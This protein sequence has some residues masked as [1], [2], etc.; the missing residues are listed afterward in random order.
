MKR[1]MKLSVEMWQPT[2]TGTAGVPKAYQ[3]ELSETVEDQVFEMIKQGYTC[4]KLNET[5]MLG[6]EGEPEDGLTFEG[7]WS[8]SWEVESDDDE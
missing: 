4:G 1:T 2:D 3:N 6:I 7:S 5:V 8:A